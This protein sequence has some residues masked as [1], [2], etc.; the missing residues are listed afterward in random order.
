M[1]VEPL[2]PKTADE[3]VARLMAAQG[4]VIVGVMAGTGA[5]A[6]NE[7]LSVFAGRPLTGPALIVQGKAR[8]IAESTSTKPS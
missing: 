4:Y 5:Y 7:R 3:A 6:P 1:G 8:C 2:L